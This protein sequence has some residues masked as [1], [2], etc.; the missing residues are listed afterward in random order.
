MGLLSNKTPYDSLR[1]ILTEMSKFSSRIEKNYSGN[2][3]KQVGSELDT[4]PPLMK[5]KGQ[6]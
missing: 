5:S 4:H 1:Q 6:L 2:D 3:D